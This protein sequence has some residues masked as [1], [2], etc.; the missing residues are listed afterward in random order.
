MD[1]RDWVS[2]AIAEVAADTN[3]SADTHLHRFALPRE[4]NVDL[5]LKDESVHPTGSGASLNL[6]VRLP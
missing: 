4:W 5:Y 1:G 6:K 3:R 2:W